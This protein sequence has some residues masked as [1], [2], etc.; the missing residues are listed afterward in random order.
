EIPGGQEVEGDGD[1][2][3]SVRSLPKI[4]CGLISST[5]IRTT[6]LT[7]P[8]HSGEKTSVDHSWV[9]PITNAPAR[10]PKAL[11][12]PP[13]T[14]AANIGRRMNTPVLGERP[15]EAETTITPAS[16]ASPPAST[17]V[18]STT[19]PV[20]IPVVSARSK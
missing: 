19:R 11:P 8:F 14:T 7:E 3:Q 4:P 15:P 2:H 9:S 18:T 5:R 12:I 17:H 16:P 1:G 13:S 6:K 20:S 10:A